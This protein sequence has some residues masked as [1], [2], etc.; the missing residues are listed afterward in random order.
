LLDQ[1]DA[2][3][4]L[5]MIFPTL[6]DQHSFVLSKPQ[7]TT[8]LAALD[9]PVRP[10]PRMQRLLAEPGFFDSELVDNTEGR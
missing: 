5:Q 7:W 4:E 6:A 10:L 2:A 1:T 3:T 9:A 8:F